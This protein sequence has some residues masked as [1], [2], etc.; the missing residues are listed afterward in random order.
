[1]IRVKTWILLFNPSSLV[2]D[3]LI[4]FQS[5]SIMIRGP[6]RSPPA[7]A[8]SNPSPAAPC[9]RGRDSPERRG[10]FS[11]YNTAN[12]HLLWQL[13]YSTFRPLEAKRSSASSTTLRLSKRARRKKLINPLQN[14]GV[15]G[16]MGQA[17][18]ERSRRVG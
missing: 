13:P 12:S 8:C 2:N 1:M 16:D 11:Q 6:P 4:N 10:A 3:K 15:I 7:L 14:R 9:S 5:L 18:G 17:V